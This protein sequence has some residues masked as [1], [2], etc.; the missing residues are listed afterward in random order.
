MPSMAIPRVLVSRCVRGGELTTSMAVLTASREVLATSMHI[1]MAAASASSSSAW[2]SNDQLQVSFVF[3]L[4]AGVLR[5]RLFAAHRARPL[6]SM[7]GAASFSA[8]YGFVVYI[9]ART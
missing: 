7:L 8:T 9:Y 3:A 4:A 1:D 2:R 6:H 5:F